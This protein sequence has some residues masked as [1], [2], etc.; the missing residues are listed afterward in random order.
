[1]YVMATFV[2]VPWFWYCTSRLRDYLSGGGSQVI[3]FIYTNWEFALLVL[4]GALLWAITTWQRMYCIGASELRA[5]V[6][7]AALAITWGLI[8]SSHISFPLSLAPFIILTLPM[9]IPK[10]KLDRGIS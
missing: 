10:G 9:V 3:W 2:C 1:M 7:T 6:G 5:T 4:I 8:F